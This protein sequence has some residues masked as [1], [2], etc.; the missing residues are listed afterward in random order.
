MSDP[1][2][3]L[4]IDDE[5]AIRFSVRSFLE[6]IGY[7]VHVAADGREGLQVFDEKNPDVVITDLRMPIVGGLEVIAAIR[8]KRPATPIIA[9][10]GDYRSYDPAATQGAIIV[11]KP[12]LHLST[13]VD[14]IER[15]RTT[16]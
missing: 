13:L 3:V 4:V 10:S 16:R 9:L 7:V 14:A 11:P 15:A 12:V 6:D 5:A 2:T 8:T 1:C